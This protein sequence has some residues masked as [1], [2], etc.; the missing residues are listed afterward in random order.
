[1]V[2][3]ILDDLV[4]RHKVQENYA[5]AE[6]NYIKAVKKALLKIMAKIGYLYHTFLPR[7]QEFS[8]LSACRRAF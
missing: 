3:A 4:K 7:S 5:T 6:A 2:F 1:M 8:S